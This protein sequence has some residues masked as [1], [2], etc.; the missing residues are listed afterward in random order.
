M[1]PWKRI[2]EDIRGLGAA[3]LGLVALFGN[4]VVPAAFAQANAQVSTQVS[5][6]AVAGDA[7]SFFAGK[8]IQLVI[9]WEVGGGYDIYARLLARHLGK[10]IPGNPAIVPQN[11]PGAGS[12]QAAN[13]LY[14]IAPKDGTAIATIGQGTPLDQAKLTGPTAVF[15]G[16]EGAG[17]PRAVLAQADELV[18]IPHMPQV[19]SLNAGVAGSIV[20]YEAA[21]QRRLS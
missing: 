1:P 17:L 18:A 10:H 14:N 11:M 7:G 4:F 5:T 15:V 19:E 20:L 21:R 2:R 13:W 16:S 8:R 6:Q 12:R 3:I 9:G